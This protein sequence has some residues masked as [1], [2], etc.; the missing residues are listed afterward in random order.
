MDLFQ[1]VKVPVVSAN[2]QITT[3]IIV[4]LDRE[5]HFDK[6]PQGLP[7]PAKEQGIKTPP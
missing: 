7:H 6:S 5:I 1:L 3:Q 4:I 2:L